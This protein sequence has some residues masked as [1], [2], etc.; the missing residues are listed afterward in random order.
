MTHHLE[1]VFIF[2]VLISKFQYESWD[3]ENPQDSSTFL[4]GSRHVTGVR[5]CLAAILTPFALLI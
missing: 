2:K 4:L 3:T 1:S 5:T